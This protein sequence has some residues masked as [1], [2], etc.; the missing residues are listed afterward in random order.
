MA[1]NNFPGCA[2]KNEDRFLREPALSCC[3][4]FRQTVLLR[5]PE[6]FKEMTGATIMGWLLPHGRLACTCNHGAGNHRLHARP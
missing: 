4:D 3:D 1:R 6:P 5:C 2:A